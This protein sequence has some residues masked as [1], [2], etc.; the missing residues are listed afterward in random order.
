MTEN[1]ERLEEAVGHKPPKVKSFKLAA[2]DIPKAKTEETLEE[3]PVLTETLEE[4]PECGETEE[5][6]YDENAEVYY[7]KKCGKGFVTD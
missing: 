4:C 1:N 7:C 5:F 3:T 6:Y 2:V